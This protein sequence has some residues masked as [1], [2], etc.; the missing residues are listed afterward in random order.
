MTRNHEKI[1]DGLEGLR[2]FLIY[3]RRPVAARYCKD[4]IN[5]LAIYKGTIEALNDKVEH[6]KSRKTK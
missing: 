2:K 1:T 3:E 4:A 6:L 5:L